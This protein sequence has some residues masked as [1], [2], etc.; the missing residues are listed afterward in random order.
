MLFGYAEARNLVF[1]TSATGVAQ[2][3][4]DENSESK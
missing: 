2:S 1:P 3:F 4:H